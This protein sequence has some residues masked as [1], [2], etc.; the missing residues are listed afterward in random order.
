MSASM[1][2]Y[3]ETGNVARITLN[4]PEAGNRFTYQAMRDFIA[5]VERASQ[6]GAIVLLIRAQGNDFTLGRDQKEH[7]P[8]VSRRENLN[9]ILAAN[10][11]LRRFPGV[12]IVLLQ[13]RALGFGSGLAL[14]GAIS[15]AADNAVLGFDEIDHGLAPLVVVAYLSHFI[16]PRRADELVLTGRAVPAEE[17]RHIGLVTR[18]VPAA[19]LQQEGEELVAQL[20]RKSPGALRLIRAFSRENRPGYPDTERGQ[21]AVEQLAQWLEAGRPDRIH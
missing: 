16:G 4:R 2:E 21:E 20:I 8:H 6:G 10:A 15:I 11:A 18:V 5:A 13:G 9:L 7:L 1:I 19:E 17:A 12:S 14:H 3:E